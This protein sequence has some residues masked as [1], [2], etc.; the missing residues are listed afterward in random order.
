MRLQ[1]YVLGNRLDDEICIREILQISRELDA[2]ENCGRGVVVELASPD[3]ALKRYVDPAP[4]AS[5]G[6][7]IDLT[8]RDRETARGGYLRDSR[9]HQAATEDG[10]AFNAHLF[11]SEDRDFGIRAPDCL[12]CLDELAFARVE[13]GCLDQ[14][15]H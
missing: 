10:Y 2:L 7:V 14:Q 4:C 13:A 9:S 12:E 5:E 1:L 15:R 11:L 8:N 3:R 6:L